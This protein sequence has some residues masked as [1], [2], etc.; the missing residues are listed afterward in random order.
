ML[1][2][3]RQYWGRYLYDIHKLFVV[4]PVKYIIH[5]TSFFV[6]F[7]GNLLPHPLRTSYIY[8]YKYAPLVELAHAAGHVAGEAGC[9][10]P[11]FRHHHLLLVT[12]L[13]GGGRG[14]VIPPGWIVRFFSYVNGISE[15]SSVYSAPY[16]AL[17]SH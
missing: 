10:V 11:P 9:P 15:M 17:P 1:E 8:I 7:L 16:V 14:A 13:A 5:S 4:P 6:C 2:H 3:S 12:H